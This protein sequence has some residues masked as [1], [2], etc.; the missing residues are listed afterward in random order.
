MGASLVA[1][2]EA[3]GA[4]A[5]QLVADRLLRDHQVSLHCPQEKKN[6]FPRMNYPDERSSTSLRLHLGNVGSQ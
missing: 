1:R 4:D 6:K 3:V 2:V 5:F